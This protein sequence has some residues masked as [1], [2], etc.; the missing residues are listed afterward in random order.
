[1]GICSHRQRQAQQAPLI[2]RWQ[3]WQAPLIPRRVVPT[4]P[5]MA[6]IRW[7]RAIRRVIAL[8][9]RRILWNKLSCS[10][11]AKK[12]DGSPQAASL[13]IVWANLGQHLR[14]RKELFS[15]LVRKHGALH[16]KS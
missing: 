6:A 2:P 5:T 7:D 10:L 13:R 11:K 9:A 8:L 4:N 12:G 3:A 1:M 16:L 15:H 14:P